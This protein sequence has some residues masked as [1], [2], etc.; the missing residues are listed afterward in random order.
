MSVLSVPEGASF[1]F[2]RRGPF[3]NLWQDDAGPPAPAQVLAEVAGG[4]SK[5]AEI[6]V[7]IAAAKAESMAGN[8]D[9]E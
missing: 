4:C 2:F 9:G 7:V 1:L 3:L 6:A 8:R 5:P